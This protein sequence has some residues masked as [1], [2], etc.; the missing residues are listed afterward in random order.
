VNATPWKNKREQRSEGAAGSA[1]TR[2]RD[3]MDHL[4]ER[5]FG[6][7][8]PMSPM[9]GLTSRLSAGPR[10]DLAE[11]DNDI[12]IKAELPGMDPKEV[13]IQ[14]VGNMLSIRGEKKQEMEEK[15]RDYHF[16][17]RQ[18]GS[19]QRNVQLP[20]SINPEKVDATFKDGVLTVVIAKRPDAKR[21]RITVKSE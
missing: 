14:V 11:S 3:E 9:G 6:G 4:F 10:L 1:I 5:F 7:A 20:S 2:F 19:F 18:Y 16:V 21:K 13:D 12:T 15:K 8:W 17:E